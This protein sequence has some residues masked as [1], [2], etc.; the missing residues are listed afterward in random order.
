[1]LGAG[2]SRVEGGPK[3]VGHT[4]WNGTFEQRLPL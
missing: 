3:E 2:R 4:D 1:M